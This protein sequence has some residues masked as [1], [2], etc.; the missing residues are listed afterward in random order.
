MKKIKKLK[1][2]IKKNKGLNIT[3]NIA[4]KVS[5]GRFIIRVDADDWLRR[6]AISSLYK[7]I[8][9]GQQNRNRFF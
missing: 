4:I 9:K 5:T 2:F 3:N 1:L 7:E 8:K 6:D